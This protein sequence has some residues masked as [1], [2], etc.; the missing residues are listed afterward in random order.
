MRG[1]G[2]GGRRDGRRCAC[3][4]EAALGVQWRGQAAV[5]GFWE[6]MRDAAGELWSDCVARGRR[7]AMLWRDGVWELRRE[8]EDWSA[9]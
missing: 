4:G 1:G 7:E 5:Q 6:L 9:V 2:D 3:R 8:A